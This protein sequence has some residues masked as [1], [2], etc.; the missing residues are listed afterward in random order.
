MT[1]SSAELETQSLDLISQECCRPLVSVGIPTYNRSD[2]LRR[3]VESVLRQ[4][5]KN[6]EVIIANNASTDSTASVCLELIA[7]DSRAFYLEQTS[8]I[9]PVANFAAA[10]QAARGDYFMWLGDDDWIDESYVSQC[11]ELLRSEPETVLVSG[12]PIYYQGG[13]RKRSGKSFNI[14]ERLWFLRVA[15]YYWS[16]TDNGLFYGVMRSADIRR[17]AFSNEMG[18]DWHLV[19]GLAAIGRCRMLRSVALHRELG[20]ATASL[21]QVARTLQ[22]STFA[23]LLPT[24]TIA[25]GAARCILFTGATYQH[26]SRLVRWV[27]AVGVIGIVVGK[28]VVGHAKRWRRHA[29][30]RAHSRWHKSF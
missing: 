3:S 1:L 19:A 24:I 18:G 6:I 16:V 7:S 20:G 23:R 25:I 8:N 4:D 26:R 13:M 30:A 22:L 9:G 17:V 2:W 27:L 10:L 29:V 28:S 12:E 21:G 14:L 5:Y 11:V 15:H